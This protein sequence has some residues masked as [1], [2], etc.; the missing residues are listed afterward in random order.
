[1]MKSQ[2]DNEVIKLSEERQKL[3]EKYLENNLK[4]KKTKTLKF[5]LF[6]FS[7]VGIKSKQESYD[8]LFESVKYADQNGFS[9]I[10][11]PERHFDKFGGLYPNPAVIAAS[12]AAITDNINI[13]TGS[14][15]LPI[16]NPLE[17]AESWSMVDNI[18]NGRIGLGVA[19]G[20]HPSDFV[21]SPSTYV[22]RR[23]VLFERLETLEGL[24]SGNRLKITGVNNTTENLKIYPEPIQKELPIWITS[25][26]NIKTWER[27]GELGKNVL[28]ALLGQ[29]TIE[30]LANNIKAYKSKLLEYG[31]D[32]NKEI[33]VMIHTYLGRSNEVVKTEIRDS[34]IKYLKVH[35][36]QY[37]HELLGKEIKVDTLGFSDHDEDSLA[38]FAFERY[39]ND[40]TL[41]GSKEKCL[42]LLE[43]LRGIG[44]TEIASLIDF[45]M[46]NNKVL[47]SLEIL[48]ELKQ[49]VNNEF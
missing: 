38:I 23:E 37:R 2:I 7:A 48:N 8:L 13:R 16:H 29:Q 43:E 20:W 5:G 39:F 34:F 42:P 17:T 46:P 27:A 11:T 41:L 40:R 31:H 1:M 21:Y 33:T 6:S 45:G 18:S 28:T 15:V 30:E 36:E 49:E 26:N 3:Y 25:S 44:V 10:W 32:D 22:N 47:D 35:M 4:N 14:T 9:S 12:I 24:W 19:P